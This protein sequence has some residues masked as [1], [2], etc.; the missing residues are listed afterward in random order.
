MFQ[1]LSAAKG[2]STG[3]R[4]EGKASSPG[5]LET[6]GFFV[7]AGFWVSVGRPVSSWEQAA[8]TMLESRHVTVRTR[9]DCF[10]ALSCS[11]DPILRAAW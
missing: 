6:L 3:S 4:L 11:P 9:T 10:M 5:V 2:Q 1:M 8:S 7:L